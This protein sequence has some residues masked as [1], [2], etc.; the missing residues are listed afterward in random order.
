MLAR[1]RGERLAEISTLLTPKAQ[2]AYSDLG[3]L[4]RVSRPHHGRKRLQ[5]STALAE[6]LEKLSSVLGRG[7][8]EVAVVNTVVKC[9]TMS[10]AKGRLPSSKRDV[11]VAGSVGSERAER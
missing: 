6:A 7:R 2:L 8:Y 4:G 1:I 10:N 9:Q 5:P 3:T 11:E